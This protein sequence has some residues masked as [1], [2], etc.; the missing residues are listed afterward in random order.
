[1]LRISLSSVVLL[2]MTAVLTAACQHAHQGSSEDSLKNTANNG[3]LVS[4]WYTPA[5]PRGIGSAR[6]TVSLNGRVENSGVLKEGYSGLLEDDVVQLVKAYL[7]SSA[8][9]EVF[10]EYADTPDCTDCCYAQLGIDYSGQKVVRD[11]GRDSKDIEPFIIVLD[12]LLREEAGPQYVSV[13]EYI[14]AFFSRVASM[15]AMEKDCPDE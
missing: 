6:S 15:P 8:F 5:G 11:L 4:F 13:G 9:Q 1:M 14:N 3:R 2:A 12:A 10:A 7:S